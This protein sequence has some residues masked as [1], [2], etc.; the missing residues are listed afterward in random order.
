MSSMFFIESERLKLIPLNYEQ[1]LLLQHN[2]DALNELLG[3]SLN[4]LQLE[5][6]YN[7]ETKDALQS[8]WLPNTRTYPDLYC[9]YTNWQIILKHTNTRIGGISFGGYPDDYGETSVGYLIDIHYRQNGYATEA[10]QTLLQWG[11]K[12]SILKA[13]NADTN[14]SNIASQQVLLKAGFKK[15]TEC[16]GLLYFKRFK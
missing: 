13:V 8:N 14:P 12:F 5:A 9:W 2:G 10:L 15:S 7:K 11:F 1:L 16:N 6:A 4:T 3:L